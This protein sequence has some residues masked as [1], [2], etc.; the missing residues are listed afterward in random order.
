MESTAISIF[1]YGINNPLLSFN[2]SSGP[3]DFSKAMHGFLYKPASKRVRP[4]GSSLAVEIYMS[5]EL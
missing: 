4:N 5:I 3:P 2:V 1:P